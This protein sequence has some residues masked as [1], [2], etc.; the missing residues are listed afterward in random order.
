M[1]VMEFKIAVIA[2]KLYGDLS[3]AQDIRET[4][5]KVGPGKV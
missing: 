5:A 1:N 2:N 4:M 3:V